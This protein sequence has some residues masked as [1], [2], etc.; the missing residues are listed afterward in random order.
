M[1]MS[2]RG[3]TLLRA[4]LLVAAAVLLSPISPV[5]LI[6]VPVALLLL[7]FRSAD[8]LSLAIGVA[9][10]VLAFG[11]AGSHG[12]DMGWLVQRGWALLLGGAFVG[13]TAAT[14]KG[15]FGRSLA[16]VAIAMLVV[17]AL[18]FARPPLLQELDW[19]MSTEIRH[20]AAAAQGLVGSLPGSGDTAVRA[21]YADAVYRWVSFQSDVYPAFLALASLAALGVAWFALGRLSGVV[22]SL[23][24]V[25]EFRFSDQLV[26]LLVGGLALLVLPFGSTAFR[27]GENAATFM[28]ALYLV[29]GLAIIIWVSAAVLTSAWSGWLLAVAGLFLYPIVVG[30]ALVLGLTDTWLDLRGRLS[31]ARVEKG[32]E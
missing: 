12:G 10:L 27:I 30:T 5:L 23:R 18:G 26:W 24:P 16:A 8:W 6:L 11:D 22:R 4:G 31:R 1:S 3:W 14:R 9:T 13:A 15:L 28:G 20:A 2:E 19:W 32:G 25:R 21:R 7:A 29:R 17:V